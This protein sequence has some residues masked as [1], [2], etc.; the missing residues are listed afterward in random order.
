MLYALA[1]YTAS[2]PPLSLD[3]LRDYTVIDYCT[4]QTRTRSFISALAAANASRGPTP[5][6]D[7]PKLRISKMLGSERETPLP[8]ATAGPTR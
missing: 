3:S 8:A 5:T 7:T 6:R 4:S 1:C 2:L